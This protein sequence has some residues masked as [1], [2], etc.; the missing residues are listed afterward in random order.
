MKYKNSRYFQN[1]FLL[2]LLPLPPGNFASELSKTGDLL[3]EVLVLV[4]VESVVPKMAHEFVG[5]NVARVVFHSVIGVHVP[6]KLAEKRDDLQIGQALWRGP[7]RN[8]GDIRVYR[9][10]IAQLYA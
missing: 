2:F 8:L 3:L 4:P 10:S 7:R 5:F 9:P 6:R 1:L